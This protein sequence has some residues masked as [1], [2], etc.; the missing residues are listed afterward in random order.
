MLILISLVIIVKRPNTGQLEIA[1]KNQTTG[2]VYY[3]ILMK[4][5][6]SNSKHFSLADKKIKLQLDNSSE[7]QSPKNVQAKRI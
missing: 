2:M 6:V 5:P 4:K 7:L 1:D 3:E